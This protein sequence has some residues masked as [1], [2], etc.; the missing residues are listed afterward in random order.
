MNPNPV[1]N[2]VVFSARDQPPK[3]AKALGVG[4]WWRGSRP[5]T[6]A[7][8][9]SLMQ[10]DGKRLR[11]LADRLIEVALKGDVGGDARN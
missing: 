2:R 6:A 4:A 7:L 11:A 1:K 5:F 8:E 9:R 3:V 10:E